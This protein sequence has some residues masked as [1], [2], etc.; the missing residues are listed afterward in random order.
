MPKNKKIA[1]YAV[2]RDCHWA[3]GDAPLGVLA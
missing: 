2:T 3:G 1:T